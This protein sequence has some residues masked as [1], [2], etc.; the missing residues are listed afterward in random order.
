[1][2]TLVINL[3]RSTD[4]RESISDRL[5]ELGLPFEWHV[6]T[7]GGKLTHQELEL[8]SSRAAF[9]H[10]GR[11]MHRNE[12]GCILSHIRVWKDFSNSTDEYVMVIEDDMLLDADLPELVR[13]LDWIPPEA[14]VVNFSWDMSNPVDAKPVTDTRSLCR[15]DSEV[16]RTGSYILRRSGAVELLR[17]AFPI[18]MPVDS[19]MGD[20]RHI[21]TI[22]GITPRPVRWDDS[23]A[24]ATW[25]D[26]T[27]ESFTSSSRTTFKGRFFRIFNRLVR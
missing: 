16:M 22:Y 13:T 4:R 14:S 2:R 10:L 17:H 6:G 11:E 9:A 25:T 5:A 20:E 3:E 18:R 12:I 1:M 8:Y 27:M 15:F 21:G 24:S 26:A 23:K 7:D 19:L